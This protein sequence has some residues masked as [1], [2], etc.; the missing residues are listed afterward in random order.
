MSIKRYVADKDTTITNAYLSNLTE[1]ADNSNMGASD[2]L[3]MFSIYGQAFSSS[4]E[5]SRILVQFPIEDIIR[6]RNINKLPTSG[7]V[8]FFLR[9][10]NVKHPFSL[11]RDYD[12]KISVL[13]QSWDEGYGL[14]MENYSDYGWGVD[15]YGSGATWRYATS[16][17][18]WQNLGGAFYSNQS[19]YNFNYSFN[20][21]TEDIEVDVTNVV[22][23]WVS[24]T[25][26][27]NGFIV[28][29]S[30]AFEDGT[31][32][33]SFYT[34]KFSGR[35]SEYFYK[36]PI[37]EARWEAFDTDDRTNFYASSSALSAEDNKMNIYF[38]NRVNGTPKNIVGNILPGLKLYT[39]SSLTNEITA[40]YLNLSNPAAG[41]YRA[42]VAVDTTASVLY[43][44]WYNT[45]SLSTYFSSEFDVYNR[46][47]SD[48]N[49]D[50]EYIVSIT[51]NKVRYNPEETAKFKIFVR[52][53][54][55]QPTIY[56]K[57]YNNI[58]NEII[59]DLYYKIFRL[60]D[61]Y[62]V[63]DYS[64]GSLAYTKTS[65][66]SYGNYFQIDMSIFEKNHNYGIKL[67]K[68]NGVSLQ[69]IET[70]FKFKVA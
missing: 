42:Q 2:S 57:A 27:N 9:M 21:G 25:L 70:I 51:N 47:F 65:Y 36:R 23:K 29:L 32:K 69:E 59:P 12:A 37:I 30:G 68:W 67:A 62:V 39:D 31:L 40:S 58:E 45:S 38:Y 56:T 28:M 5:K 24:E 26:D 63:V 11:P 54:D 46:E 64:T 41:I 50:S 17:A 10:F 60:S 13:S 18:L 33:Q 55:W 3:E 48:T 52:K 8:K 43:D 19:E 35:G 53:K 16:G 49:S 20:D 1:K 34:K 44:K 66:D 22:E 61:N 4:L 6:D 14:D 15:K 7:S